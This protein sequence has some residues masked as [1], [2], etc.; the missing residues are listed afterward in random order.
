MN[1]FPAVRGHVL[2]APIEHSE[3]VEGTDES[4]YLEIQRIVLHT[5]RAVAAAT[6]TERTYVA[7][8]GSQQGNRH[9]HWHVVPCPPGLPLEEQQT[10]LIEATDGYLDI[11]DQDMASLSVAIAHE[12]R[13][14]LGGC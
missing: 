12:L 5:A 8:F 13:Q 11:P 7:S 1:K 9:I 2:V 14:S 6:P 4:E 3:R 10:R